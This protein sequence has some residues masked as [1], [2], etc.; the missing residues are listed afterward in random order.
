MGREAVT[1]GG[2]R[3]PY[4]AAWLTP[5]CCAYR[6]G[7]LPLRLACKGHGA[8]CMHPRRAV[9]TRVQLHGDGWLPPTSR[10]PVPALS[11]RR[12]RPA[13][14]PSTL[15]SAAHQLGTH[16]GKAVGFMGRVSRSRDC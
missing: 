16:A 1:H 3:H 7:P 2:A 10:D 8:L 4:K 14:I 12:R 11:P 5:T 15:P 6:S 9:L 13:R